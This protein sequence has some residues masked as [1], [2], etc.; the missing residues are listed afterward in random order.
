MA[1]A[2]AHDPLCPHLLLAAA[3]APSATQPVSWPP[4]GS[5]PIY[6]PLPAPTT[7]PGGLCTDA[8]I[9]LELHNRYRKR[10]GAPALTWDDK[11]ASSAQVRSARFENSCRSGWLLLVAGGTWQAACPS[12]HMMQSWANICIFQHATLGENLFASIAQISLQVK[13]K[14]PCS[15]A[16]M[17]WYGEMQVRMSASSGLSEC[18]VMLLPHAARSMQRCTMPPNPCSPTQNY[19]WNNPSF[20]ALDPTNIFFSDVGAHLQ[21]DGVECFAPGR[22]HAR[23]RM[24]VPHPLHLLYPCPSPADHFTQMVWQSTTKIGCGMNL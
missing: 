7:L 20:V 4:P 16:A 12:P 18:A 15:T 10:H 5:W 17:L 1:A 9:A 24:F 8:N 21:H 2:D 14:R 23:V 11:L 13:S 19:N 3:V 6:T 22:C